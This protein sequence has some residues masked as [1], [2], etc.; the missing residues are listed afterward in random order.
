MKDF[1]SSYKVLLLTKSY[2]VEIFDSIMVS[3]WI[4]FA[5]Y[6]EIH[7]LSLLLPLRRFTATNIKIGH[8]IFGVILKKK[9]FL[10]FVS[11]IDI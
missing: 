4:F 5:F 1:Q 7:F 6:T 2:H 9:I 10:H 3:L 11:I 8:C